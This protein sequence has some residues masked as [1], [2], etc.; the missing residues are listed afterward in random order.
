MD[1]PTRTAPDGTTRIEPTNQ[2]GQDLTRP[3]RPT[4]SGRTGSDR[5]DQTGPDWNEPNQKDRSTDRPRPTECVR[6]G[7][8]ARVERGRLTSSMLMFVGS[9]LNYT[10]ARR[11]LCSAAELRTAPSVASAQSTPNVGVGG[12][13]DRPTDP[14]TDPPTDRPTHRPTDRPTHRPTHHDS[15]HSHQNLMH[16]YFYYIS[17]AGRRWQ[18]GGRAGGC[19]RARTECPS[20]E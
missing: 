11:V 10:N 18:A 8:T 17:H 3:D 6:V 19:G 7:V 12:P 13:T 2:P 20:P 16:Q 1:R 4:D 14:P 15:R 9:A 5:T